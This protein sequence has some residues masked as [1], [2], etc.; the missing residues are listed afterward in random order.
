MD[1]QSACGFYARMV[2]DSSPPSASYC[3]RDVT[4]IAGREGSDLIWFEPIIASFEV[5]MMEVDAPVGH[6]KNQPVWC[7][8]SVVLMK[9]RAIAKDRRRTSDVVT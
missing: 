9:Q 6:R 8:R 4:Y 5:R 2:P 7:S 1:P 3:W